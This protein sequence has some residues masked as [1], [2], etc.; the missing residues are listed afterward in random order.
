MANFPKTYGKSF[1]GEQLWRVGFHEIVFLAGTSVTG[2][3]FK[4]NFVYTCVHLSS[5]KHMQVYMQNQNTVI[6]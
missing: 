5:F 2:Q 3:P 6:C 1:L 4:I